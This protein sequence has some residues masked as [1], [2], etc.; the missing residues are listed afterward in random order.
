MTISFASIKDALGLF[1]TLAREASRVW[2][3]E[4][5]EI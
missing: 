2:S 3:S 4:P 5:E 1:G